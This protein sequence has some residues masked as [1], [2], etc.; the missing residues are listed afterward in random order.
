MT[1]NI[2]KTYVTVLFAGNATHFDF[3]KEAE[4]FEGYNFGF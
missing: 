4:R 3:V 2:Q 1:K